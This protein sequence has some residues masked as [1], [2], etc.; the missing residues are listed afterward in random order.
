MRGEDR[1]SGALFSYV[2]VEAR[3]A[4]KHPLRA[5]RAL[6]NA[7][8]AEFDGRFC[9]LYEAGGRPSIAPERLLQATLLQLPYSIRSERQLVERLEFD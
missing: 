6:T 8:L 9:A 4:A 2:D 7:A 5:M 1:T 3:I